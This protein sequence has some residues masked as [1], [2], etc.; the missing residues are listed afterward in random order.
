MQ[1]IA[2]N[3]LAAETTQ[4]EECHIYNPKSKA[5]AE[6]FLIFSEKT[7]L[8]SRSRPEP[9]GIARKSAKPL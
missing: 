3:V 2:H 5:V 4:I 1:G 8:G 6:F 9:H 7:A